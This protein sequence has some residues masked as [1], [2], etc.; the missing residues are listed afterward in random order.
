[1]VIKKELREAVKI[2]ELDG[3][4]SLIQFFASSNAI[5]SAVYTEHNS[6]ILLDIWTLK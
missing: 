6:G 1:M 5:N 2:A 3:L 4:T